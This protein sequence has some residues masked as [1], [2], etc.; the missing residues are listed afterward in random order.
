[1][2]AITVE[3]RPDGVAVLLFDQPGSKAN[4]LTRELWTEFGAAL[5]SSPRELTSRAWCWRARS[6]A[7]SSRAPT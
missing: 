5:A 6:R 7:S 4:V 1:M 2:S 3:T